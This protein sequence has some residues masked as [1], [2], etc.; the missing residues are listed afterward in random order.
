MKDNVIY[1]DYDECIGYY[2]DIVAMYKEMLKNEIDLDNL[3][4]VENLT[5][6]L[7]EIN[8]LKEYDG[9][10]V[11][12]ENNGMGFTARKYKEMERE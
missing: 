11:L 7:Q 10:I 9:L 6:E 2:D 3:E 1:N 12:S 5:K 8:E 4:E